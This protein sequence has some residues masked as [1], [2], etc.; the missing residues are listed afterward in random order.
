MHAD[1]AIVQEDHFRAALV[2]AVETARQGHIAT[3]GIV[4][5]QP[6]TG[7]GY[8]ERAEALVGGQ[9]MPVY[10]VARFTEKPPLEQAREFVASGR[11]YWNAGYLPGRWSVSWANLNVRCPPFMPK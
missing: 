6:E 7:F 4:P 9:E 1:H 5:T 3:I 8:I 2:V 10:R 11:F